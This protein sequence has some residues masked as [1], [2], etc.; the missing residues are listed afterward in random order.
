MRGKLSFSLPILCSLFIVG[1]VFWNAGNPLDVNQANTRHALEA[2]KKTFLKQ[3]A[4]K[5]NL[6]SFSDVEVYIRYDEYADDLEWA[7]TDENGKVMA[8]HKGN[9]TDNGQER[10][11][12]LQ[13]PTGKYY[14]E[15]KDSHGDGMCCRVGD[16]DGHYKLSVKGKILAIGG[17]FADTTGPIGFQTYN[18][19]DVKAMQDT[20]LGLQPD[21]LEMH[22]DNFNICLYLTTRAKAFGNDWLPAFQAAKKK[23]ETL[24][25]GDYTDPVEF[26]QNI[27][28]RS[29]KLDG[30]FITGERPLMESLVFS[31]L[32]DLVR[33]LGLIGKTL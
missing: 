26:K 16:F 30:I 6:L 29:K 15:M 23:W 14:F 3:S 10:V 12:S 27:W 7:L 9:K 18:G 31:D 1:R 5:R 19:G 2:E 33:W 28:Q 4:S 22:P 11:V 32:Q 13:V 21:C 20:N 25:V 17:E 8:F 24:I